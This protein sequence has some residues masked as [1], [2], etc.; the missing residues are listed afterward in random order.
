MTTPI[1]LQRPDSAVPAG[2]RAVP[3]GSSRPDRPALRPT[4]LGVRPGRTA[5]QAIRYG[6][7]G[8]VSTIAYVLLYAVLRVATPAAVANALALVVTAV[9]NTAANR[10]L[11]FA[12]RG[13][14]RLARDHAAGL[15]AF[16]AALLITTAA[17]SVLQRIAP[18]A[19]RTA[20]LTVLVAANATATLV[21]FL[22]LRTAL[23]SARPAQ[24]A[25]PPAQAATQPASHPA[26]ERTLP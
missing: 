18:D 20:E 14:D 16:G 10:R 17:L 4:A 15:L 26:T 3:T 1:A 6:A 24:A 5:G 13:R 7:I 8:V 23:D 12:V 21:R 11:T 19:G 22:L 9:G 2:P 25:T